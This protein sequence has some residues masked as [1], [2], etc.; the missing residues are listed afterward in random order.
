[1]LIWAV[2]GIL[3]RA[4]ELNTYHCSSMCFEVL[5]YGCWQTSVV[6]SAPWLVNALVKF[7]LFLVWDLLWRWCFL[8]GLGIMSVALPC[9]IVI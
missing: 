1:M 8:V 4:V 9:T 6:I 2:T 3:R 7:I 5:R